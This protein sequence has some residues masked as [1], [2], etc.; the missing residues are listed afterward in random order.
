[1]YF[2]QLNKNSDHGRHLQRLKLLETMGNLM[3]AQALDGSDRH[4]LRVK[5]AIPSAAMI[6]GGYLS[7]NQVPS[8]G[9]TR[10]ASKTRAPLESISKLSRHDSPAMYTPRR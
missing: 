6:P 1:M 9:Q 2:A 7:E 4:I 3:I 5:L 8:S 10:V